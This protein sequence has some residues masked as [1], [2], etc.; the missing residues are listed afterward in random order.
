LYVTRF[1][2]FPIGNIISSISDVGI[3]E[4]LLEIK[5][6]WR[7]LLPH[8]SAINVCGSYV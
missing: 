7:I 4:D 2:S 3:N 6:K 5:N 8:F 1:M